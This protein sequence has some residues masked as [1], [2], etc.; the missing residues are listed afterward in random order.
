[1]T[2]VRETFLKKPGLKMRLSAQPV[3]SGPRLNKKV[4]RVLA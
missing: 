4:A 1:M 2:E 3:W